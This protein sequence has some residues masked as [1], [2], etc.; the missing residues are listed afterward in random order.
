MHFHIRQDVDWQDRDTR[1]TTHWT[2]Y[3][4]KQALQEKEGVPPPQMRLMFSGKQLEDARRLSDY[5]I[6]HANTIHFV[7]R[8]K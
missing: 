2:V 4:V 5:C 7:L 3:Q 6:G 8:L 1:R